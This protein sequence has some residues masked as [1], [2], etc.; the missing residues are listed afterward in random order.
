MRPHAPRGIERAKLESRAKRRKKEE[1]PREPRELVGYKAST[2]YRMLLNPDI[3]DPLSKVARLFRRRFR[4]PVELFREFL[5]E[6]REGEAAGWEALDATKKVGRS[7]PLPLKLMSALRAIGRSFTFDDVRD[8]T[9]MG[10]TTARVF[11][12]RWTQL[13][14]NVDAHRKTK[15]GAL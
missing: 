10:E 14:V 2:W 7:A 1:K 5:R 15:K 6:M 11:R 12:E 3:N 8:V 13:L 4:A 9:G